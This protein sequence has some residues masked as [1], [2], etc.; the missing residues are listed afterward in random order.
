MNVRIVSMVATIQKICISLSILFLISC[1]SSVKKESSAVPNYT[2]SLKYAKGFTIEYFDSYIRLSVI[3]PWETSQLYAR[4]YLTK[5]SEIHIPSDGV[6]VQ[7]PIKRIAL[8]SATQFEFIS[9]IG[10]MN[11]VIGVCDV[12]RIYSPEI[13]ER[14]A[15]GK[16]TD[17]GDPFQMNYERLI[18][19]RP[20]AVMMSGYNKVDEYSKRVQ[21]VGV[22]VVYNNEWMENSLLARAEWIKLI[23][24]LYDKKELADSL[25]DDI[26]LRYIELKRSL[27]QATNKVTILPGDNFRGTW[28]MP[29][30]NSF[31]A[32]LYK[33]T[34]ADYF[35]QSDSTR[36]SI[37]IDYETALVKFGNAQVWIGA[38][39]KT[40]DELG[41]MNERNRLFAAF[42]NKQVYS[43]DNRT[44]ESG[45][46]DYWESAVA[47]PD[48][49]L[50]DFIKVLHPDLLPNHQLIYLKKLE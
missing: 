12:K 8:G 11:S 23:A 27:N 6:R 5:D 44:T 19:L 26:E 36:G 7:I 41:Q 14:I 18:S 16:A 46:N 42:R 13:L 34:G 25:F 30:G 50:A 35:Y 15:D 9:L 28:Y 29:G 40:L 21:Q 24:L 1:S 49:L 47:R 4:Y 10:E 38:T 31:M 45:G 2:D 17:L 32:N 48:L 33:E 20:E 37:P 43:I 22:T 39:A 3:N